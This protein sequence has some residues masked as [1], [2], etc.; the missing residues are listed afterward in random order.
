M[1]DWQA[2][3]YLG[4]PFYDLRT[5]FGFFPNSGQIFHWMHSPFFFPQLYYW[6]S[7]ILPAIMDSIWGCTFLLS[8]L[9]NSSLLSLLLPV[10]G[11]CYVPYSSPDEFSS[12]P[13]CWFISHSSFLFLFS[14][15]LRIFT[16]QTPQKRQIW[17][18]SPFEA[19]GPNINL[20]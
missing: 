4:H 2:C 9:E 10:T 20:L 17:T 6:Y 15:Y 13:V 11:F 18:I 16:D 3:N 5:S 19:R 14:K 1:L 7:F 12:I 8:Y